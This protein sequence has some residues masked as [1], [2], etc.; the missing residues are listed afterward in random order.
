M[1][2]SRR[3]FIGTACATAALCGVGGIANCLISDDPLLRPPGGQAEEDFLGRCIKCDR[4]RSICPTGCI[5]LAH[6]ENGLLEARTPLMDF[7]KSYCDFCDRCGD[8]CPTGALKTFDKE[9]GKI[10]VA[11]IQEDRCIAWR[12]PGSCVKC[13]DACEFDALKIV[14]GIPV[15]DADACN[16]CGKCVYA[17]I[18]LVAT[19]LTQGNARGVTVYPVDVFER[20]ESEKD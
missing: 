1:P 9:T 18:A 7:E 4:C 2:I 15:V 3:D 5:G 8:V 14:D 6:I 11:I 16:G 10:G 17:C 19:S 13:A 12:N 20:M